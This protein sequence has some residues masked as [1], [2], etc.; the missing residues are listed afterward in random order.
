M[1]TGKVKPGASGLL[2]AGHCPDCVVGKAHARGQDAEGV[3][4]LHRD[5][6]AP[7]PAHA[8]PRPTLPA[9]PSVTEARPVYSAKKCEHPGCSATFR[10]NRNAAYCEPHRSQNAARER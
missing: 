1:S 5:P 10:P 7:L 2:A 3:E 4:Y 8:I 6:G 9:I